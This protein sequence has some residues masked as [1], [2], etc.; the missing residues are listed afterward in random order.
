MWHVY[1]LRSL[2]DG[3]FYI[4]CTSNLEK[5]IDRHNNGGNISTS[6]RRPLELVH[7]E[8]YTTKSEALARERLI[9]NYKGGDA[10]KKL[11]RNFTGWD[12]GAVKRT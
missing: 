4:G 6:R 2:K 7:S 1:I 8:I 10:F 3:K 9:K 11:I 5:R 12:G